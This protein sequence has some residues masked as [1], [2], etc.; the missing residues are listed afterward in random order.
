[1]RGSQL[2]EMR[3][4]RL[5]SVLPL[6]LIRLVK[7]IQYRSPQGLKKLGED[8]YIMLP[9][10]IEGASCI[11]I[12]DRSVIYKHGW[13]SAILH[14]ANE[15]FT[16]HLVIGD[17][18]Y[19]GQYSCIICLSNIV[20][21]SGCVLSEHVYITDSA[22]GLDPQDGLIMKQK[23]VKKGDVYIGNSSFIGYRACIMPG[24][25]LGN[26]CVVGVNSV[27]TH[28]FPDYSMVAGSPARLIKTYSPTEKKWLDIKSTRND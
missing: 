2:R 14:Y 28:S 13:L 25:T 6:F 8:A 20:I 26:H 12:G 11:E 10:R 22:H 16:P 19:I 7:R 3:S 15:D 27:V 1:M 24:V 17:D 21:G 23:L 4:A 9:R 5:S 18:V